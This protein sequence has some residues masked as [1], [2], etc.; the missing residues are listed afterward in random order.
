MEFI[1]RYI[2]VN[3]TESP[4]SWSSWSVGKDKLIPLSR[5]IDEIDVGVGVG[6]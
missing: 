5:V 3:K 1:F 2:T 6:A 4:S